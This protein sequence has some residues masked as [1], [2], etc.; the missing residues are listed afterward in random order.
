MPSHLPKPSLIPKPAKTADM[1]SISRTG[2][3]GG[4][5]FSRERLKEGRLSA[6]KA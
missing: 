3:Y 4:Y 2:S 1:I 5:D 6:G